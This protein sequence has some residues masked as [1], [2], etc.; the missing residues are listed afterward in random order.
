MITIQLSLLC[1]KIYDNFF[2]LLALILVVRG[3]KPLSMEVRE[4]ELKCVGGRRSDD[5]SA[6]HPLSLAP[7]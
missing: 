3:C 2:G 1:S 6:G 5:T 7:E 4:T